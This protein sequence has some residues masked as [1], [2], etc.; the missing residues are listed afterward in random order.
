MCGRYTLKVPPDLLAGFFQVAGQLDLFPRFNI[1]PTQAVLTV[2]ADADGI[3][4]WELMKWGLVPSWADDPAIGN[5][6]INAR[7][8]TAAEK[9]SFRAA[10]KARRCLV[11]ADGIYEWKKEPR[12]KVPHHIRLRSGDPFGMAGLWERWTAPDGGV[13]HTCTILTTGPNELMA[14][15]H[16]RMPVIIPRPDHARWL[17]PKIK[18]PAAVADLLRPY[19]AGEMEA[20]PVDTLVNSPANDSPRC[21]ERVGQGTPGF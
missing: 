4:S 18:D 16:D 7:S 3:R 19:P 20:W 21:I 15:L 1:A 13:L 14:D 10:M 5:R 9:P 11:V 2:R 12:R 6:M 8:E 17:D